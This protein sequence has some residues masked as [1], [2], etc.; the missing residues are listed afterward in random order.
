MVLDAAGLLEKRFIPLH[1]IVQRYRSLAGGFGKPVALRA[2]DLDRQTTER[3]FSDFDEDYHISRFLH[4]SLDSAAS[5]PYA[6]NGFPQSHV[7]LDAEV[8]TI[9]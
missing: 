4:F 6:I 2:F 9:L 7:W 8:E 3:L 5:E 1:E